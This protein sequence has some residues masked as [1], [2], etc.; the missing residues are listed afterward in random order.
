MNGRERATV[1]DALEAAYQN[2]AA[3][4]DGLAEADLMLPSRCAGWAGHGPM[5]ERLPLFG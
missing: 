4:A 5:T 2:M 1:E 3:V